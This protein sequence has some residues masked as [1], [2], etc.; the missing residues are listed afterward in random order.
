MIRTTLPNSLSARSARPTADG[1]EAPRG[2]QVTVG[3]GEIVAIPG[4][5]RAGK[6]TLPRLVAALDEPSPGEIRLGDQVISGT[7]PCV[8]AV[9]QEPRLPPGLN[10]GDNVGFGGRRPTPVERGGHTEALLDRIGL[11]SFGKR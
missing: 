3:A 5:S 11:A 1:T 4:G 10:V 8:S 6:T 2:I 7:H 9:F